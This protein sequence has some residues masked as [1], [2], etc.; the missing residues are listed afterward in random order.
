M[1]FFRTHNKSEKLLKRKQIN[2]PRIIG[3]KVRLYIFPFE[4]KN[5]TERPTFIQ[6]ILNYL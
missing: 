2:N 6:I 1:L 5:T 3:I 4:M